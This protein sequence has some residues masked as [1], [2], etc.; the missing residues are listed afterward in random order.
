MGLLLVCSI[1]ASLSFSAEKIHNNQQLISF[2]LFV[3]NHF[4]KQLEQSITS[5][6]QLFRNARQF[7]IESLILL[8]DL[9]FVIVKMLLQCCKS[10]LWPCK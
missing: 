7:I 9:L 5:C 6:F 8:F 10:L 3:R 1:I 2:L 4:N